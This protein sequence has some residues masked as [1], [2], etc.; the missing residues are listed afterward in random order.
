MTKFKDFNEVEK[1]MKKHRAKY[2][3]TGSAWRFTNKNTYIVEPYEGKF[4]KGYTV[5]YYMTRKYSKLDYYITS[6]KVKKVK[7]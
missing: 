2:D 7:K 6:K 1:F 3:H 5:M 4:G